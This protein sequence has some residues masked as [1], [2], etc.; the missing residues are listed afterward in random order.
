MKVES[1]KD[2][3]WTEQKLEGRTATAPWVG[4]ERVRAPEG[5]GA[6]AVNKGEPCCGQ[7]Q[8]S[9]CQRARSPKR[10]NFLGRGRTK[11]PT[12]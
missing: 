6:S 12:K 5:D 9:G 10:T 1:M 7:G 8:E 11:Q 3:E 4:R 2:K